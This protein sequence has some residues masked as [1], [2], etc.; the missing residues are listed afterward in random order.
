MG[1]QNPLY[2]TFLTQRGFIRLARGDAHAARDALADFEAAA[3]IDEAV[4][5]PDHPDRARVELG[6]AR[7]RDALQ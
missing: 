7:A 5:P 1:T 2:S 3:K 4:L 6:L